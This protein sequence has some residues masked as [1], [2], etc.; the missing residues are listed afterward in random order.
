V[1][2]M[3]NVIVS[4]CSPD[5]DIAEHWEA[6]SRRAA[7]N[8]FMN[9]AALKAAHASGFAHV[10]VLLAW[11]RNAQPERLIG[12]WAMREARLTPLWPSF[13]ATPPYS[14]AWLSNPVVDPEF[15]DEAI[16]AFLDAIEQDRHLPHV[17]R[18]RYLDA[19]SESYAAIVKAL[20]ARRAHTVKMSERERAFVT[21]DLGLKRSGSTRKKLRQDWHRL[22]ALGMVEVVNQRS[23]EGAQDAFETYLAMEAASWKGSRGTALLCDEL[24][25][26]FARR[27]ISMLAAERSASV[28]LLK[29][30][31]RAVAAQ[32]LLYCGSMAYTWRTAFDSAFGKF[33]PGTLLVDKIT[34]RLFAAEGIEAIESCAPQGGFMKQIWGGRRATVDLLV[35]LGSRKSLGFAAMAMGERSGAL[36]EIRTKLR[37]TSWWVTL[38]WRGVRAASR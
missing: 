30:D 13:L 14:Y 26:A 27:L 19:S 2:P 22:C 31:G 1:D 21:K 29:V 25:A 15:M 5:Q 32:V 37:A 38:R 18:L 35:D 28:A 24:E 17:V 16:A 6:L 20:E 11:L 10:H 4:F 33:S 8:V 3:H 12:L 7:V 34:E 36:R 9:P 23:R